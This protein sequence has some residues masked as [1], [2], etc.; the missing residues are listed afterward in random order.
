MSY[1]FLQILS[2][3]LLYSDDLIYDYLGNQLSYER[4]SNLLSEVSKWKWLYYIIIPAYLITKIFVVS[5][6]LSVGGLVIGLENGFKRFI[7]VSINAEFIFVLPTLIKLVWFS[8]IQTSYSLQ[9]LQT[10]FPL[11]A[12][13]VLN[14][15]EVDPWLIYPLQLI[16]VFE[17]LYWL[18]LAYQLKEIT[19]KKFLYNLA[20][21]GYTYGVCL[22]TWA[23]FVVFLSV[24]NS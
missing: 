17:L 24:T 9:D 11:S 18:A 21:V 13:S 22:V 14:V 3:Y 4:I 7:F 20:F 19:N 16:N 8:F 23:I 12:L 2:D 5:T 6:C 15:K 1:V 10:F